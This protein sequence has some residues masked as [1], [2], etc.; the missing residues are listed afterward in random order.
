MVKSLLVMLLSSG[1]LIGLS[2]CNTMAGAGQD[3]QSGGEAVE[4]AARDTQQRMR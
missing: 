4:D 3:V 1:M 2:G